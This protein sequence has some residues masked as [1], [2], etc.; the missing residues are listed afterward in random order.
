MT[1]NTPCSYVLAST[2]ASFLVAYWQTF[3]VGTFRKAAGV[4]YPRPYAFDNWSNDSSSG[5]LSE[6]AKNEYLFNCAQRAHG[7]LIEH[8]GIAVPGMLVAGL[9]YPVTSA[10]LGGLWAVNRVIYAV[11]YTRADKNK[12]SGRLAGTGYALCEMGLMGIIG[13]MAFDLI[14]A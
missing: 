10:V 1:A 14:M 7:Q 8:I 9:A 2:T 13:K 11:G 5:T 6:Q 4:A 12:G 3:K